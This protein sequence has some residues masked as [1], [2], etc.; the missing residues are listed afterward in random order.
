MKKQKLVKA[1]LY[2][3]QICDSILEHV[4]GMQ[5]WISEIFVPKAKMCINEKGYA[6]I[7]DKPRNDKVV[8][9]KISQKLISDAKKLISIEKKTK[10]GI[11]K[12][13]SETLIEKIDNLKKQQPPDIV[14]DIRIEADKM[15]ERQNQERNTISVSSGV[16]EMNKRGMDNPAALT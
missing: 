15:A 10:S 11:E 9:I 14:E 7:Q 13:F 8:E 3:A 1:L 6:F 16:I 5:Y 12:L 2:R 4:H